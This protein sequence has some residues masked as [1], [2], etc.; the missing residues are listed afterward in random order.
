AGCPRIY[1]QHCVCAPCPPSVRNDRR[2]TSLA[3]SSSTSSNNHERYNNRNGPTPE[4]DEDD[5]SFFP[6]GNYWDFDTWGSDP[7]VCP[8]HWLSKKH[9]ISW[10]DRA[11]ILQGSLDEKANVAPNVTTEYVQSGD[12]GT[13]AVHRIFDA[14]AIGLRPGSGLS[15]AQEQE[16]LQERDTEGKLKTA[17]QY[18]LE[19]LHALAKSSTENWKRRSEEKRRSIEGKVMNAVT[20]TAMKHTDY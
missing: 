18:C 13:L 7:W 12:G 16:I 11:L 14:S 8:E 17:I 2:R 6:L 19:K 20:G 5:G 1:H 9:S 3:R 4:Q 10:F 15:P